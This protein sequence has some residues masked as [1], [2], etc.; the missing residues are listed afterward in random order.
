MRRGSGSDYWA[1]SITDLMTS[2]MV[3][4]I[5]LLLI[6]INNQA[7]VNTAATESVMKDVK[8]ALVSSGLEPENILVDH[9]DPSTIVVTVPDKLM[10]F[11]PNGHELNPGGR[12]FVRREMPRLAGVLCDPKY[13]KSV[14]NVIVEGHSDNTPYR[15]ATPEENVSLN[16]KLSQDRS[17]EVVKQTLLSLAGKPDERGCFVEKLSASGRGEQ[18]LLS[19]AEQSRRVVIKVR[20]NAVRGAALAKTIGDAAAVAPAPLLPTPA[21][22]KVLDL[23]TRLRMVPPQPVEFQLS[24]AETNEYLAYALRTTPRPGIDSVRVKIFP[25]N[26]LSTLTVLDFDAVARWNP[27]LIPPMLR[28]VLHGK[29]S[30]LVDYRFHV[31]DGKATFAIEKAYY[32][33]TSLPH[34]VVRK[35]LQ[36][37]AAQQPERLEID[38]PVPLPFGLR[39]VRTDEGVVMGENEK[40]KAVEPQ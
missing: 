4:F 15:G 14:E 12:Q 24:Q 40:S 27:L 25:N 3:I 36:T 13:R 28:P 39:G 1:H 9:K 29:R 22:R 38:E 16:L 5:L 6:F 26:Y 35:V 31:E 7:S 23:M 10:T 2:L 20:V 37:I 11:E 17:M 19:T 18:E 21:V 8:Q 32:Q 33:N 34:F 30:I